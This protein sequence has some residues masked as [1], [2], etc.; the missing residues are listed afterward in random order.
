MVY[1][2]HSITVHVDQDNFAMIYYLYCG[3]TKRVS[4]A[5]LKGIKHKVLTK[6]TCE[7]RF[8]VNLNFRR[9]YR[10]VVQ[11]PGE[12][13]IVPSV[14][15]TW[16]KMTVCDISMQGFRFVMLDRALINKG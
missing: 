1:V 11:I 8:E 6:C 5:K 10:K 12:V 16:W 2:I 13:I 15:S 4:I 7:N 9:F 3:S 14:V